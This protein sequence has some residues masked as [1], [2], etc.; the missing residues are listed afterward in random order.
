M[1]ITKK[2]GA[3]ALALFMSVTPVGSIFQTFGIHTNVTAS[4]A[5]TI[6]T[7][8]Q[9]KTA[10]SKG[11]TY[12]IG[13]NI[14]CTGPLEVT[15]NLTLNVAQSG[16]TSYAIRA[17]S[18]MVR[19]I[20]VN[21]GAT[22]TIGAVGDEYYVK[23]RGADSNGNAMT[24]AATVVAAGGSKLV[25]NSG[26]ILETKKGAAVKVAERS[27]FLMKGGSIKNTSPASGSELGG[28]VHVQENS[29]FTMSGGTISAN[30]CGG[31]GVNFGSTFNMSGGTISGNNKGAGNPTTTDSASGYG[32]GVYVAGTF[33]MSGGTIKSNSAS[34]A[35]H[36]NGVYITEKGSMHV[37]GSMLVDSSENGGNDVRVQS[38]QSGIVLEGALSKSPAMRISLPS[39]TPGTVIATAA[40]DLMDISSFVTNKNFI[41]TN[42]GAYFIA[43]DSS[44]KKLILSKNCTI[45]YNSM[46]GNEVASQK[47]EWGATTAIPQ[48]VP[49][50]QGYTFM[51]WNTDV[52][53][54]GNNYSAGTNIVVKEDITLYA[55]W[56]ENN[57]TVN[58]NA[59]G[60][61]SAPAST[62]EKYSKGVTVTYEIPKRAGYEFNGWNTKADGTGVVYK[63]GNIVKEDVTLYAQ[64]IVSVISV[65]YNHNDGTNKA[66][67]VV[68]G[69]AADGISIDYVPTR[70]GYLFKGWN[71]AQN[72]TGVN[73]A[74]GTVSKENVILYAQWEK[75]IY[76][77]LT[78]D[79]QGGYFNGDMKKKYLSGS[80]AVVTS[81]VPQK[82]G[83]V[84]AGWNTKADGTGISYI[85]ATAINMGTN[86]VLYAQW[87]QNTNGSSSEDT[88]INKYAPVLKASVSGVK[89][90]LTWT[91]TGEVTGYEVEVN[92]SATKKKYKVVYTTKSVSSYSY[93]DSALKKGESAK[94]RI[95]AYVTVN[96]KKV[97]SQYSNIINKKVLN[98]A[99]LKSAS[100][101]K[102]KKSVTL[103][104][105]VPSGINGVEIYQKIGSGKYKKIY[106]AKGTSKQ[107]IIS[108][109]KVKKGK[110]LSYKIR[111]CKKSGSTKIY[112]AYSSVKTVKKTS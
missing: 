7:F 21:N 10:C 26:M 42:Q 33:N 66:N 39:N 101:G 103:K 63:A 52:N 62:T 19:V 40:N 29:T 35:S 83:Y 88:V 111:Y 82:P 72:G 107:V 53:G 75:L 97:Y 106:T 100:Y 60:G 17:K 109:A 86:I 95:R 112:S 37:S 20:R 27:T 9:L 92:S 57:V 94:I 99:A 44:G 104:W 80:T 49:T 64:W 38:A 96:G 87:I 32:G 98:K 65:Q 16:K 76:Y 55:Q 67:K 108:L 28:A 3:F 105:S 110:K 91:F 2:L 30:T 74:T 41:I 5:T 79:T 93:L 78:Y 51:G 6:T 31:V 81:E 71:T 25:L 22:L 73:Y 1:K 56:S 68:N 34:N 15:Q 11:G 36:G 43:K 70:E 61:N 102:K 50:R 13:A 46:G 54:S 90:K 45:S 48:N 14:N 4:A 8:E 89:L 77:T 58:Y 84:F 18:E 85:A 69:N 47:C 23:F 24:T 12:T 59:N